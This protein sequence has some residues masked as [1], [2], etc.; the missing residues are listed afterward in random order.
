MGILAGQGGTV[1]LGNSG[2]D[3]NDG[4]AGNGNEGGGGKEGNEGNEGMSKSGAPS[5]GGIAPEEVAIWAKKQERVS[6]CR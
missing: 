1:E 4:V 3:G 5:D 6:D 2:N